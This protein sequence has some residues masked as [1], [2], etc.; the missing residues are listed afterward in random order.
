MSEGLPNASS[1]PEGTLG[2]THGDDTFTLVRRCDICF[3]AVTEVQDADYAEHLR[4]HERMGT[5]RPPM[6]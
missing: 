1:V 3:A 5:N 2:L 6:G 4:W